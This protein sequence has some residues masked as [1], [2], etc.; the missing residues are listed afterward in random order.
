MSIHVLQPL[1]YYR[2]YI[3]KCFCIFDRIVKRIV[4][5]S[6]T[7]NHVL[8]LPIALDSFTVPCF[9]ADYN[10]DTCCASHLLSHPDRPA[11]SPSHC[12]GLISGSTYRCLRHSSKSALQS[13]CGNS[14]DECFSALFAG[15]TCGYSFQN[16]ILAAGCLH[17]YRTD[18][19]CRGNGL[20]IAASAAILCLFWS[21]KTHS[22]LSYPW[23]YLLAG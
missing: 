17:L 14:A 11:L 1:Y 16:L 6:T 15:H 22:D 13:C 23:L 4:F 19:H 2:L 5:Y 12:C 10:A 18:I 20:C 9:P 21:R 3:V 7:C 8:L